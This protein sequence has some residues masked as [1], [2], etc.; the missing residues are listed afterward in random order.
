MTIEKQ[1]ES[2]AVTALDNALQ[3]YRE[4]DYRQKQAAAERDAALETVLSLVPDRA[5]EGV[6][7][8]DTDYFKASLTGKLNRTLNP[9]ATR[10]LKA[11]DPALYAL[12]FEESPSLNLKALR[13]LELADAAS[14]QRVARTLVVK[15]GK[16]SLKVEVRS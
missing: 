4:A 3:A 2:S 14:Y 8:C 13:A 1:T 6:T 5:E 11:E 16:P 15:P 10:A 9:D 12:V 7:R